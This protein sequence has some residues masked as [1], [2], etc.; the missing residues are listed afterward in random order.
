[1]L[2]SCALRFPSRCF[3]TRDIVVSSENVQIQ[4]V[5]HR[6]WQKSRVSRQIQRATSKVSSESWTKK[7]IAIQG[8]ETRGLSKSPNDIIDQTSVCIRN[9]MEQNGYKGTKAAKRG[10]T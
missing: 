5:V 8:D 3:V 4:E 6:K 9:R 7:S 10:E 2:V 1:M